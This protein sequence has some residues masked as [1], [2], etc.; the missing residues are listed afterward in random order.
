MYCDIHDRHFDSDYDTECPECEE[1]PETVTIYSI[2]ADMRERYDTVRREK[3]A[4]TIKRLQNKGRS[5]IR[6]LPPEPPPFEGAWE[7]LSKIKLWKNYT[8]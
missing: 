5:Q 4:E 8:W 3:I 2:D 7:A 1:M 6:V